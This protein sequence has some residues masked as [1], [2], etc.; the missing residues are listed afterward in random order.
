M[1]ILDPQLTAYI[2][3][4]ALRIAQE[5][6][7]QNGTQYGVGN[8]PIH[9]HNNI[10]APNIPPISVTGFLNLPATYGGVV[11]PTTLGNQIVTQGSSS[12]GFGRFQSVGNATFPIYPIPIIYGNGGGVDSEFN[13]G[14][15]PEGTVVFF[16]NGPASSGLYI[17]SGGSWFGIAKATPSY[18]NQIL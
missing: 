13:G 16:N 4:E 12:R 15:A 17:R 18:S 1:N 7:T 8:I 10:D 9:I 11:A 5:V 14:Q 2:Q 6:Y 3:S